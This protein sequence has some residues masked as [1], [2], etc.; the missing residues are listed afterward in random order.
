[1]AHSGATALWLN[2]NLFTTVADYTIYAPPEL[3]EQFVEL[4]GTLLDGDGAKV[5]D[6]NTINHLIDSDGTV[7][8]GILSSLLYTSMEFDHWQ[9]RT[10]YSVAA[11]DLTLAWDAFPSGN[12]AI[13][14]L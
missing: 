2:L 3:P 1:L 10:G 12:E 8:T 13:P 9:N 7:W 11:H 14:H 4:T 5:A 6:T